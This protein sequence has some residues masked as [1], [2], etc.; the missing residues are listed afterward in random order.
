MHFDLD[1]FEEIAEIKRVQTVCQE[2]LSQELFMI[3]GKIT[4]N[5]NR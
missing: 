4:P 5:P 3:V 1:S 2:H